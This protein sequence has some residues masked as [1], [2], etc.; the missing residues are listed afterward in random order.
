MYRRK[1][2]GPRTETCGTPC[3]TL[4]QLETLL[5]LSLPLNRYWYSKISVIKIRL[6]E[7]HRWSTLKSAAVYFNR[8]KT[9]GQIWFDYTPLADSPEN[10]WRN[11]FFTSCT[12]LFWVILSFP[13][14]CG[15]EWMHR[16]FRLA[17]AWQYWKWRLSQSLP[18]A[19]WPGMT[20]VMAN[21][22]PWKE[23]DFD[24]EK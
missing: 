11:S 2:R 3:L 7:Q 19:N 4:V 18:S 20:N 24:F 14:F 5:L 17:L 10:T 21:I 12:F 15:K 9:L 23:N 1:S 22:S 13:T 16:C 6:I 8:H